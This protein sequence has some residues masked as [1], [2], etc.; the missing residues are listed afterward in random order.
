MRAA[1]RAGRGSRIPGA[2]LPYRRGNTVG[3]APK[4]SMGAVGQPSLTCVNN[5]RE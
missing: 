4:G 1:E 3:S 2:E 5:V